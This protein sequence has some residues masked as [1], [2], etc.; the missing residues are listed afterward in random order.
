M[1]FA[2]NDAGFVGAVSDNQ[3]KEVLAQR[4]D[5]AQINGGR[6]IP[7]AQDATYYAGTVLSQYTSGPNAGL[8][9]VYD[10]ANSSATDGSQLPAGIL[11]RGSDVAASGYGSEVSIIVKGSVYSD[12]CVTYASGV[13][14][15][16]LPAAVITAMGG[17]KMLVHGQNEVIF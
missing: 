15:S 17:K 4:F 13:A 5:L 8:W 6:I 3:F 11:L 14:A 1:A 9:A 12:L 2:V 7:P 16:G 10:S